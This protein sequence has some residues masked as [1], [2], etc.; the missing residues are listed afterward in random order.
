MAGDRRERGGLYAQA[1]R[2]LT[3]E[4]ARRIRVGE[5]TVVLADGARRT[6]KGQTA[7]PRAEIRLADQSVLWRI[8][9][10]GEIAAGRAYMDGGWTSPDLP[11]L[12]RLAALNREALDL[13]GGPLRAPLQLPRTLA[14]RARRN[15]PRQARRNIESHYDLGNDFY[16]LFLDET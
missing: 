12:L 5:L 1:T 8:L 15:T 6:F 11:A 14:H 13:T 7:G 16:R 4:V 2:R 3:L 10:G 9:F